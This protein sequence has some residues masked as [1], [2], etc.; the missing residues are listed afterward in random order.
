MRS[1]PF[2]ETPDLSWDS[3]LY[4]SKVT[5][6][7]ALVTTF[8]CGQAHHNSRSRKCWCIYHAH[9]S[10]FKYIV[11]NYMNTMVHSIFPLFSFSFRPAVWLKA[12]WKMNITSLAF[13]NTLQMIEC[14]DSQTSSGCLAGCGPC[15]PEA[16]LYMYSTVQIIIVPILISY[17]V[18]GTEENAIRCE[19]IWRKWTTHWNRPYCE[20]SEKVWYVC[21]SWMGTRGPNDQKL[22]LIRIPC[23]NDLSPL[24]HDTHIKISSNDYC[25][26]SWLSIESGRCSKNEGIT[27]NCW[28]H[29]KAA[30]KFSMKVLWVLLSAMPSLCQMGIMIIIDDGAVSHVYI[31]T[32]L[33]LKQ[34][35]QLYFPI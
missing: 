15:K 3:G 28:K 14:C 12:K 8:R 2:L 5:W 9:S 22:F 34:K 32:L 35:V 25:N 19:T 4:L 31:H 1:R 33:S 29:S 16:A 24:P 27:T 30:H 23:N 11:S 17:R 20:L 21:L 7:D 13:I 26:H 10:I 6:D 18:H